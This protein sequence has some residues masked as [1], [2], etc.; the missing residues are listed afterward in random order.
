MIDSQ[1]NQT[2]RS[3]YHITAWC[4]T[5]F[6]MTSILLVSVGNNGFCQN[7]K[8]AFKFLKIKKKSNSNS[9]GGALRP[10]S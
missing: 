1:A 8:K 5:S 4:I 10:C 6:Y 7:F 3:G 2:Q 9:S